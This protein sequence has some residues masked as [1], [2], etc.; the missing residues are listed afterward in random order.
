MPRLSRDEKQT[1]VLQVVDSICKGTPTKQIIL[2]CMK[3]WGIK[4]RMAERYVQ[5][6]YEILAKAQEGEELC[7]KKAKALAMR[8]YLYNRALAEGDVKT[9]LQTLDSM[10]KINGLFVDHAKVEHGFGDTLFDIIAQAN[11]GEEDKTHL[12]RTETISGQNQE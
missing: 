1:R 6:A 4:E 12:K 9:A 5:G 10:A 7:S 3:T 11:N 2:Q 8:E